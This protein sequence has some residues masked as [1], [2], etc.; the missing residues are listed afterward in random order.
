MTENMT[1]KQMDVILN[2]VADK[3]AGC[4]DMDEVKKAIDEVRN[5]AKKEK[6]TEQAFRV[7]KRAADLPKP[8]QSIKLQHS[9]FKDSRAASNGGFILVL[10]DYFKRKHRKRKNYLKL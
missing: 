10:K 5:M 8:P 4:K 6:P 2:L 3:F 9:E 1:D 7:M